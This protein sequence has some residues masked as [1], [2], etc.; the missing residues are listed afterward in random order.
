VGL[1]DTFH[2][3]VIFNNHKCYEANKTIA[4]GVED[5]ALSK[6][7]DIG[8]VTEHALTT[9]S[10]LELNVPFGMSSIGT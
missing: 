10:A 3:N 6:L 1:D 9:K 2:L 4:F 8:Q 5:Q 7:V